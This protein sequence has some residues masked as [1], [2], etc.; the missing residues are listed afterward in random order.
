MTRGFL[1]ALPLLSLALTGC[2]TPGSQFIKSMQAPLMGPTACQIVSTWNNSVAFVPDPTKG[3]M[4]QPGFVG[5]VYLFGENIDFPIVAQGE[6]TVDLIDESCQPPRLVERWNFDPETLGRLVK[7]DI[8]GKGFTIFCP[9]KEYR[10]DMTKIRLRTGFKATNSSAP[11]Y[12][13]NVVTLSTLNGVI[14]EGKGALPT[15]GKNLPTGP[16][17]TAQSAEKRAT[18]PPPIPVR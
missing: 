5:R 6:M 7:C 3:G 16:G 9:S 15:P 10:P 12:T 8:I 18:L 11:I 1:L 2:V 17:R 13:E 4:P 14:R